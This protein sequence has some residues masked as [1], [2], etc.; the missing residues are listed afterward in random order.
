M[1]PIISVSIRLWRRRQRKRTFPACRRREQA[2]QSASAVV[3]RG[4]RVARLAVLAPDRFNPP[5]ASSPE[6]TARGKGHRIIIAQFQSASGV[7][8]RG[9]LKI[10]LLST[11]KV[12]RFNPPLASSPE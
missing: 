9:N 7:V 3:A 2:F 12:T 10:R 1:T 11:G 8:A 6:E 5:L 4:N